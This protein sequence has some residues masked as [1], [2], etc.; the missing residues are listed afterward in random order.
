MR[1]LAFV[2]ESHRPMLDEFVMPAAAAFDET[3]VS[4][5]PQRC[6]SASFKRE[7]WNEC[8]ADKLKAILSLPLDGKPTLYVD[9]DVALSPRAAAWAA[10]Y[11]ES[12]AP[13][14]I[15]FSDD[16]V[17]WC[18][19][20]MLFRPTVAT[21]EWWRLIMALSAAWMTPDQDVIHSL[22]HQ[23]SERGG[24]MPVPVSVLPASRVSN[25][26]TI[27]NL[28]V[29]G[30]EEFVVPETCLAWHANWTIGV[31]SKMKMLRAAKAQLSP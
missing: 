21:A 24:A 11:A 18:A 14:E 17:Q 28:T 2:T 25:W 23:V 1:L 16:V 9:C 29:W 31:E 6:P 10:E 15:A 13:D 3:V 5:A 12:M 27:G 22:R 8:M 26:A 7:G 4:V 30:G 20:V 19:G